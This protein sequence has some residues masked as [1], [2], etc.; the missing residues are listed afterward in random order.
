MQTHDYCLRHMEEQPCRHCSSVLDQATQ[1]LNTS[2]KASNPKD[3]IGDTKVPMHLLSTI[4]K[5]KWAMA[6][7]AG[8]IK[9]GAWNWR[10]AGVR[11][12]TYMSAMERHLEGFKN[13]ED[14]DPTDGTDHLGNIMACCAILID[15]RAAGKLTDDRPPIVSH[16]PAVAE[17]EALMVKLKEQYAD[18]APRHYTI[19]DTDELKA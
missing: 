3:A 15:A 9:Y 1:A 12:S 17:A 7:F 10:A 14:L 11:T 2:V 8:L 18:K 4:A 6:Q 13:G 5:I 19:A 16:R